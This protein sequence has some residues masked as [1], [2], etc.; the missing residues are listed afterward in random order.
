MSM[1]AWFGSGVL[2][3]GPSA[4]GKACRVVAEVGVNHNGSPDLAHQLIDVAA[5]CG[6]DAVK[7]QTFE[8]AA[9]TSSRAGTA[10]YQRQGGSR[11][12]Q[13]E[14][15]SVLT[16][17]QSVWAELASHAAER[18]V[19][20]LST[21][22][23]LASLEMLIALGVRALKVPSGELDNLPFIRRVADCGLPMIISTGLGT[24]DEVSAAVRAAA[25]APAIALLHCVTAYPAPTEASNLLAIPSM[26]QIFG[27]PVGWSDHT[28]GSL[29]AIAA[30][31][32]GASILEKHVTIGHDLPGPDHAASA[33]PAEFA[34]YVMNVRATERAL[35]DGRKV[36][37]Q[38]EEANRCFVRRSYH[39][40]RD[41]RAGETIAE[42]DVQ[43][44]RP[45]DGLSATAAVVGRVAARS[46]LAGEPIKATDLL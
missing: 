12:S 2:S 35:G 37:T 34:D 15:L 45:A 40:C 21:P 20:F 9:V 27:I 38:A 16:L 31:A 18:E 3:S 7:F 43:L 5:D 46:V 32:L 10:P 22:F 19:V 4:D 28:K 26:E 36:P 29:T 39:A 33:D 17:Q 24:L 41:L 14:V 11:R 44:L 25:V 42:G 13:L 6:A 1:H 30:V 8:P 23:D